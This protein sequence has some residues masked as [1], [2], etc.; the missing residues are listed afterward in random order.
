MEVMY[1]RIFEM[2][3]VEIRHQLLS[4][5]TVVTQKYYSY[6]VLGGSIT[7]KS[8]ANIAHL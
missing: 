1:E 4:S 7:L 2:D 3:P 6:D 8:G 5:S